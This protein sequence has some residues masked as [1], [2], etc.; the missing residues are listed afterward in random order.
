MTPPRAAAGHRPLRKRVPEVL[1]IQLLGLGSDQA[2]KP[3]DGQRFDRSRIAPSKRIC[4]VEVLE[5]SVDVSENEETD[6]IPTIEIPSTV[7][8]GTHRLDPVGLKNLGSGA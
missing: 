1:T 4:Q 7:G 8:W 6:L 3:L 5:L 2:S